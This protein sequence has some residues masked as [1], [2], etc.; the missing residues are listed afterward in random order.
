MIVKLEM[1]SGPFQA[2]FI[3]RHHVE[4]R[5]KLFVPKEESFPFPLNSVDVTGSTDTSLDVLLEKKH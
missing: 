1:L 4:P 5:V 2:F 3:Y